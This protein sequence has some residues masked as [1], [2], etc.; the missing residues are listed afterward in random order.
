MEQPGNNRSLSDEELDAQLS[1]YDDENVTSQRTGKDRSGNFKMNANDIIGQA[2]QKIEK[3]AERESFVADSV[4][5]AA[6]GVRVL[7]P[8]L[9]AT[10][11][12]GASPEQSGVI[13]RKV[14][15]R[16]HS[17]TNKI[18]AAYG[19]A[20]SEAPEWLSAT[21]SGQVIKIITNSLKEGNTSILDKTEDSYISPLIE[22]AEAASKLGAVA[23]PTATPELEITN[24]LMMATCNVMSEFQSFN[25]FHTNPAQVAADISTYFN[26]RV[27]RGTLDDLTDRFELKPHE[28]VYMANS[29][30]TSAGE[31][32]AQSWKGG[33][34]DTIENLR[35]LDKS[36]RQ[37]ITANGYSL[38]KVI[39][40]FEAVYQGIELSC[41]SAIRTLEPERERSAASMDQTKG[42]RIG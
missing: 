8:I 32:M 38:E 33:I 19:L 13:M 20:Q 12:H 34:Q 21:I 27:I 9:Q 11:L 1:A 30:L 28:R 26:D 7:A 4:K 24:A 29:L 22:H 41:E 18:I 36:A 16:T 39:E 3:E 25:Y 31:M 40:R 14:L 42:Q 10:S 37:A 6:H 5:A 17:D 35:G 15:Q 23:Y 2:F